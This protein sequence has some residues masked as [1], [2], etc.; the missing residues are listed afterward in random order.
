MPVTPKGKH[1]LRTSGSVLPE[2][3]YQIMAV[4]GSFHITFVCTKYIQKNIGNVKLL[5][6]YSDAK[7]HMDTT[8][9]CKLSFFLW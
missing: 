8:I 9:E 2:T 3:F 5:L 6:F 7:F 1:S 4:A